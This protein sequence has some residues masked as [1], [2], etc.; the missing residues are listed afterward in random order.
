MSD[1]ESI[2]CS[3]NKKPRMDEEKPVIDVVEA[4][5]IVSFSDFVANICGKHF[6]F[7]ALKWNNNMYHLELDPLD[8]VAILKYE[9]FKETQVKQERQKILN[10]KAKGGTLWHRGAISSFFAC[11]LNLPHF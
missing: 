3:K 9:I 2:D 6:C 10:L 5:K 8:D 4:V 7:Q 11:L 1:S